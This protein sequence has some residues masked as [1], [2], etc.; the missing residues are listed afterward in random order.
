MGRVTYYRGKEEK[1]GETSDLV[2]LSSYSLSMTQCERDT[3]V[4]D[5]NFKRATRSDR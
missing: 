2:L 1:E 5:L 4:T 3:C